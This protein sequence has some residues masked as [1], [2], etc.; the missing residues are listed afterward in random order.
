MGSIY[1]ARTTNKSPRIPSFNF[2]ENNSITPPS[3]WER[4]G[5]TTIDISQTVLSTVKDLAAFTPV[6]FLREAAGCALAI[7]EAVD[8]VITN[9]EGFQRLASHACEIVFAVQRA[10]EVG[11]R[12]AWNKDDE[13]VDNLRHLLSTLSQIQEYAESRTGKNPFLRFVYQHSDEQKV[14]RFREE[15]NHALALFNLQST[16]QSHE[17]LLDIQDN[18]RHCR[19]HHV[20]SDP[21]PEK[22]L[23]PASSS[24][25]V[26]TSGSANVL[27][28]GP[29]KLEIPPFQTET[30]TQSDFSSSGCSTPVS[31]VSR[32]TTASSSSSRSSSGLPANNTMF[33]G[34]L[35]GTIHGAVTFNNVSGDQTNSIDNSKSV[36]ERCGGRYSTKVVNSGNRAYFGGED[37]LRMKT[38]RSWE[39][40]W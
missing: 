20:S 10:T 5:E 11:G 37:F 3:R 40:G 27:A 21:D 14:P 29:P 36:W 23:E 34:G 38:Q 12:T 2:R 39:G 6:P 28:R 32:G 22:G 18:T 26:P 4:A 31:D 17:I 33:G 16:I 13:M 7:I 8:R 25:S 19:L 1:S 30:E 35:S 24:P 15:L 9:K